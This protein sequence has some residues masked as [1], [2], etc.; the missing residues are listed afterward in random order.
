MEALATKYFIKANDSYPFNLEETV[1]SLE[2]ALSYDDSHAGAHCLMARV[3]LYYTLDF[4]NSLFHFEK[5]RILLKHAKKVRGIN[6][7]R[8]FMLETELYERKGQIRK[9]KNTLKKA[10]ISSLNSDESEEVEEALKRIGKK[11]K[12][13]NKMKKR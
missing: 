4:K 13:I 12:A 1:E 2:Y 9:A 3:C 7:H 5:A 8:L 6:K 11:V 10:L